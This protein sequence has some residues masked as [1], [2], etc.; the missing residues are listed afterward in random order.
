MGPEALSSAQ[1]WELEGAALIKEGVLQQSAL[2]EVDTFCSPRKQFA[3]LDLCLFIFR[4]GAALIE[5]GVP[6]QEL[7]QLPLLARVRRCKSMFNSDQVDQI[8]ALKEEAG[9]TFEKMRLEYAQASAG[10]A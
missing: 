3:L 5:L 6:V 2:D 7:Q 10:N 8:H 9:R 4:R 1:R